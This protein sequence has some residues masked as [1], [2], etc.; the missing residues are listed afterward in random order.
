LVTQVAQGIVQVLQPP[1]PRRSVESRIEDVACEHLTVSLRSV[2]ERGKIAQPQIAP[3]PQ[4]RGHDLDL[5]DRP[6]WETAT[7]VTEG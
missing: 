3:E 5:P 7:P 6:E 4:H 2:E 1:R